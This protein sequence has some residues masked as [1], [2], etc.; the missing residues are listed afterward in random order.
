MKPILEFKQTSHLDPALT[1]PKNRALH[2]DKL[3]GR[4]L[5]TSRAT[6]GI[7]ECR[8][9]QQGELFNISLVGVGANGP[10][11]W[12]RAAGRLLANLDE[13]GGQRAVAL[14]AIFEFSFMKAETYIRL[15]KGVLVIVLYLTFLDQSG[16]SNYVTREFFY[17]EN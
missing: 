8:I 3:I 6:R 17:G 15:N 2:A 12:P 14:V 1:D 13:E 7:A 4:W 9:E 16:R 11:E 5:N 10:I